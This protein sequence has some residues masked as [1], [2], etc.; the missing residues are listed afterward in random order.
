MSHLL[1][2]LY[3]SIAGLIT[4]TVSLIFLGHR[5]KKGHWLISLIYLAVVLLL[6][7]AALRYA[8]GINVDNSVIA[9][10]FV[11]GL[12]VVALTEHWNAIEIGRAHV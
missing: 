12:V 7:Q 11:L 2:S 9:A 1:D 5:V 3:V 10:G 4:S 8:F 6:S